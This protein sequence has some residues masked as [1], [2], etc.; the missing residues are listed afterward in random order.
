MCCWLLLF[1]GTG[2]RCSV[3]GKFQISFYFTYVFIWIKDR[4][5]TIQFLNLYLDAL[6]LWHQILGVY[7]ISFIFLLYLSFRVRLFSRIL[8]LVYVTIILC[9]LYQLRSLTY[10]YLLRLSRDKCHYHLFLDRDI[11]ISLFGIWFQN[12]CSLWRNY[13]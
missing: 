6:I 10:L 3:Q 9:D 7:E 4:C 11:L 1:L 8:V 12:V 13:P 5:C 2:G